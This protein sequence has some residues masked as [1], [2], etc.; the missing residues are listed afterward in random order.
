MTDLSYGLEDRAASISWFVGV[1]HDLGYE[2]PPTPECKPIP[3]LGERS[4]QAIK[5][6]HDAIKAIDS[7][8]RQLFALRQQLASELHANEDAL[9]ARSALLGLKVDASP[10]LE[11]GQ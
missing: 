10:G 8:S 9:M 2:S 7:L 6:G 3:P 4:A 1:W 5:G 11:V